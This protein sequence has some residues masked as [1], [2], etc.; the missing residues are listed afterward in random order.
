MDG[1]YCRG[2][3]ADSDSRFLESTL[4]SAHLQP[5]LLLRPCT[6]KPT[7]RASGGTDNFTP[8]RQGTDWILYYEYFLRRVNL[9]TSTYELSGL[10]IE[11]APQSIISIAPGDKRS[12]VESI[13]ALPSREVCR[14]LLLSALPLAKAWQP[15]PKQEAL[16]G[17]GMDPTA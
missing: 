3:V 9:T 8:L 1:E 6:S 12:P 14:A 2:G 11:E 15:A 17:D 10:S 13:E 7:G 5:S 16:S 4:S